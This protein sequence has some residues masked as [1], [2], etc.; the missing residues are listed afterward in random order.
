MGDTFTSLF[1]SGG[2]SA[3]PPGI[4]GGLAPPADPST[5][6]SVVGDPATTFGT[7][8][9]DPNVTP[10]GGGGFNPAMLGKLA[11]AGMG[12][13]NMFTTSPTEKALEQGQKLQMQNAKLAGASGKQ[14][15]Q[16]YTAGQL[17]PAQQAAVDRFKKE[18]LAKW[19]QTLATMGIP[20]SSAMADIE[21][22][23]NMKTAA[24]AQTLLQ[25][26]YKNSMDALGL[27]GNTLAQAATNNLAIDKEIAASDAEIMQQIGQLFGAMG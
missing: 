12:L 5:V 17:S 25:Q 23:V 27:S 24:Y 6:A 22:D 9:P 11:G 15:L 8:Q 2:G 3:V 13:Y 21:A 10:A 1:G 7:F 26:N 14:Q 20:E 18:N 16:Q 19:R 4:T